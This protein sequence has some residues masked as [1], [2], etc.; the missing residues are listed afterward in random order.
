MVPLYAWVNDRE[1]KMNEK[2]TQQFQIE[3]LLLEIFLSTF[4]DNKYNV[5]R[6]KRS[7]YFRTQRYPAVSLKYFIQTAWGLSNSFLCKLK[8]RMVEKDTTVNETRVN[9][10]VTPDNDDKDDKMIDIVIKTPILAAAYFTPQFI[11]TLN[12]C[13]H[14]AVKDSSSVTSSE[15]WE[16]HC[17][18][19]G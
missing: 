2:D 9:M 12:E 3:L 5:K 15:Y 17:S 4:T 18:A 8:K 1:T 7:G 19:C 11:F 16:R 6:Y 10:F 13:R 14:L